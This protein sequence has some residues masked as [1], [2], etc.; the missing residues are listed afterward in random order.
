MTKRVIELVRDTIQAC[1]STEN[2]NFHEICSALELRV[3]TQELPVGTD[4]L[5]RGKAIIINSRVQNRE[6]RRFTEFHELSH[7]LIGN[8]EDL[9]G[10]LHEYT[11]NQEDEYKKQLEMLCNIG[12]AEFLMPRNEFTKLYR[13]KGFNVE[14]I[15]HAAHYFTAS[16]IAATIQLAQ[17]APNECIATVWEYGL[18]P[19]F[20]VP[21]QDSLFTI[22]DQSHNK[23]KLYIVYS[24]SSPA[25][26]NRWLAKHTV[27]PDDHLINQVYRQKVTLKDNCYIHFPS[28]KQTCMCEAL[29]YK[30]RVYAIFHLTSPP[31]DEQL[32]LFTDF[33]EAKTSLHGSFLI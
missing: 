17:I 26:S 33:I 24:A 6:R 7:Y 12:A 1:S 18:I 19:N 5:Q 29:L 30:N 8:D 27:F 25:A 28:W 16:T 31:V 23:P 9:I 15:L 13:E 4:G 3:G 14:L 11:F 10:E 32:D 22:E 2:P 20:V 21:L